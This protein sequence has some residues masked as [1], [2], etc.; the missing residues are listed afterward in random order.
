MVRG[1]LMAFLVIC[2][3]FFAINYCAYDLYCRNIF[4]CDFKDILTSRFTIYHLALH[5]PP[6]LLLLLY[7][8]CCMQK[9]KWGNA[10]K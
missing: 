2:K 1:L 4:S 7:R 8:V 6:V 3:H 9:T 10:D 5:S